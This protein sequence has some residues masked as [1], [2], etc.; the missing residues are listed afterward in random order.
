MVDIEFAYCHKCR[1]GPF[2][3]DECGICESCGHVACDRCCIDEASGGEQNSRSVWNTRV[4]EGF[5]AEQWITHK[6]RESGHRFIKTMGFDRKTNTSVIRTDALR[7]FL[8]DQD[9]AE[10]EKLLSALE[11]LGSG[12]P[13]FMC[14]KNG[15]IS[16][17]EVKSNKSPVRENQKRAIAV[18]QKM[19][20]DVVVRRLKASFMVEEEDDL[21]E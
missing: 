2:T 11:K 17:A 15:E 3:F 8:Q 7:K 20:Y 16:F 6:L 1:E 12:I 4:I 21:D 14:L 10:T 9:P 18:L 13:D 19:G 5:I